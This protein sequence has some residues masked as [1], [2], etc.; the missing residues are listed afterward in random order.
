[1]FFERGGRIVNAVDYRDQVTMGLFIDVL[2]VFKQ[3]GLDWATDDPRRKAFALSA[4]GRFAD[5]MAGDLEE[6][7]L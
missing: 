3:H 1:M 6:L 4:L 5:A 7:S 2:A